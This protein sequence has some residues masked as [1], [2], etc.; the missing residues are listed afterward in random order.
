MKNEKKVYDASLPPVRIIYFLLVNFLKLVAVF[1]MRAR[2]R[3][4]PAIRNLKGPVIALGN[5]P[6]FLDPVYMALVFWPRHVHFVTTSIF[7]RIRF[8]RFILQ[9]SRTIPKVQ[10][11]TDTQAVKQ[12]L[13]VVRKHGVLGIYPEGQRSIDGSMLS[14]DTAIGRFI[15]KTN[16]SIVIV[17]TKGAYFSWPRWSES[18]I[19][20]GKVFVDAKVLLHANQVESMDEASI[21]VHIREALT[22][23]EYTWQEKNKIRYFSTAPARGL[24]NLC[25]KC[26]SCGKDLIMRS[27]RF[28]IVCEACGF[29]MHLSLQG[30]LHPLTPHIPSM[31]LPAT[32]CDW[33]TWQIE[34]MVDQF[35]RQGCR[36]EQKAELQ[37]ADKLTGRFH[38]ISHGH[39]SFYEQGM[40]FT[41]DAGEPPCHKKFPVLNRSGFIASFGKFFELVLADEVYRFL[42]DLGQSVILFADAIRAVQHVSSR[43]TE[44]EIASE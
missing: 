10:F 32:P 11:R 28:K 13:K 43:K 41:S 18:W 19:R 33:H 35:A 16:C 40:M 30:F 14:I 23:N 17:H 36:L 5:H 1:L 12:M 38:R 24:H 44:T 2:I 20:I 31:I 29:G 21:E 39:V 8:I 15:K 26:P 37:I 34:K 7:Y 4:D 6:S 27:K 22:Y 25:H 42:P 9:A 3:K